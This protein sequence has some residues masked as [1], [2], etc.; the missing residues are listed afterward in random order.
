MI[1]KEFYIKHLA[2]HESGHATLA[3][4]LG[5][6]IHEIKIFVNHDNQDGCTDISDLPPGEKTVRQF[7]EE[8]ALL[9]CAGAASEYLLGDGSYLELSSSDYRHAFQC[10]SWLYRPEKRIIGH[11]NYLLICAIN[12]LKRPENW[13]AVQSLAEFIQQQE[14]ECGFWDIETG[15]YIANYDYEDIHQLDGQRGEEIIREAIE[16]YSRPKRIVRWTEP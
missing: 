14:Q 10:L 16:W 8:K 6:P 5:F 11:V 7:L 15:E 2:F 3:H 1:D 9:D 12:T 13:F 4:L